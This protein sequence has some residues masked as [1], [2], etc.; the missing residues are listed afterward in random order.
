[1]A[2]T[3]PNKMRYTLHANGGGI[4][5]KLYYPNAGAYQVYAN[6]NLIDYTPWDTSLGS[7]GEL[8]K[9]R[10]CG[11]NRFVGIVNFLEFYITA[12]C[13]IRVEPLD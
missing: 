8:T 11:E 13:D 6:G 4:K 2:G 7:P 5:L 12:G 1:M 3:P 9:V 10:G